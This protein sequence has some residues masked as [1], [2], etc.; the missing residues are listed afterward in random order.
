MLQRI[1]PDQVPPWQPGQ[2]L[3]CQLRHQPPNIQGQN[4]YVPVS[5]CDRRQALHTVVRSLRTER[6]DHGMQT[7]CVARTVMETKAISLP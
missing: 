2:D 7:Y 1:D 5:Q 3:E 4:I 6:S